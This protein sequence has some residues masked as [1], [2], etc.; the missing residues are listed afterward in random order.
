MDVATEDPEQPSFYAAV[1]ISMM[2][3]SYN[4]QGSLKYFARGLRSVRDFVRFVISA[5]NSTL[6]RLLLLL[7][8]SSRA[9]LLVESTVWNLQAA[10][11]ADAHPED[12]EEH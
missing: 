9:H 12:R 3:P 4:L 5:H 11:G 6:I 8:L 2:T 10:E 1:A 7:L